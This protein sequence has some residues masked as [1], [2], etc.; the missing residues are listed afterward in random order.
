[1]KV[2]AC[3]AMRQIPSRLM[4]SPLIVQTKSTVQ[5]TNLQKNKSRNVKTERNFNQTKIVPGAGSLLCVVSAFCSQSGSQWQWSSVRRSA[6]HGE[7]RR[8]HH[9]T[10]TR[11]TRVPFTRS[12]LSVE[13][14]AW[15][16]RQTPAWRCRPSTYS[17]LST[18]NIYAD[19]F[20]TQ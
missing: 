4:S 14:R 3:D 11:W 7:P 12:L 9:T 5:I 10:H 20:C 2:I 18:R 6:R 1:M 17:F 19:V 15:S 13:D 16:R 8:M